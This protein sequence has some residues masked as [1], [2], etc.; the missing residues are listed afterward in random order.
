MIRT[1]AIGV[2][3][4]MTATMGGCGASKR[5]NHAAP[6]TT[7]TIIFDSTISQSDRD[8]ITTAYSKYR[9]AWVNNG[10]PQARV[11][12][13]I[14]RDALTLPNNVL[15]YSNEFSSNSPDG[16]VGFSTWGPNPS[17]LTTIETVAFEVRASGIGVNEGVPIPY[18]YHE[19]GHL[20][21]RKGDHLDSR[22][23]R[24]ENEQRALWR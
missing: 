13:L 5:S 10:N 21:T 2:I 24:W 23:T 14:V 11:D 12:R 17:D 15:P 4:V 19:F 22:W 1:I 7:T 18:V 3:V 16:Y 6:V 9:N 8:A 20:L